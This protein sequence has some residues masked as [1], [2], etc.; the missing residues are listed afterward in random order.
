[1]K[2]KTQTGHTNK[3]AKPALAA[4]AFLMIAVYL[5]AGFASAIS[6]NAT[7]VAKAK[8]GQNSVSLDDVESDF[9]EENEVKFNI[10]ATDDEIDDSISDD[11]RETTFAQVSIGQ[12]WAISNEENSSNQ[13]GSFVRLFWVEKTFVLE[14]DDDDENN[15][16]NETNQTNTTVETTLARGTLKI[17]SMIY[18]IIL[19]EN[20]SDEDTMV[21][22]VFSAR[23][24]A[25]GTLTLDSDVS[26]PGFTVWSGELDMDSGTDWEISAATQNS[27]AKNGDKVSTEESDDEDMPGAKGNLN[28]AERGN[29]QK[30]GLFA[31]IRAWFGGE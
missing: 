31:R 5:V 12:G 11:S 15:E 10:K 4:M 13:I 16:T 27:K 7:A 3:T 22:D 18:K 25:S 26:L 17:G 30:I 2:Q 8:A 28:A 19:D 24:N 20:A 14:S 29:G 21:F 1:M 9:D 6:I 23:G